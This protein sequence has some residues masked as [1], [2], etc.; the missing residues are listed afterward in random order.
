MM[1]NSRQ[2][3]SLDEGWRFA[4]GH[5]S[6]PDQ[7][8]GFGAEM[9]YAKS[10]E[11]KGATHP[12]FQDAAW[13]QVELPHDWAVE[14]PFDAAAFNSKGFKPVGRK[15]SATSVGWYRRTFD[16]PAADANRRIAVEF[17]GVFRDCTVWFNGHC[18]GRNESGYCSFRC[19]CTDY[20]RFG[21]QNLLVVRVDASFHEGWFYEGAGLYRHV[22]LTTTAPVHVGHWGAFVQAKPGRGRAS[23]RTDVALVNESEQAATVSIRGEVIDAQG[24]AVQTCETSGVVLPPWGQQDVTLKTALQNP[25]LWSLEAPHLYTWRTTVLQDG[26]E[27]DRLDTPFG[28]RSIRFDPDKGFFLNNKPVKIR[29]TCNHQDH[30][31]VGAALPDRLQAFRVERLQEMGCNAIRTSHN[32]PTPELL[33][34]CD[35]L[36]MLIMDEHRMMGS[37]PEILGQLE[38]LVRRDR[39]HPCV[40]LWSILNEEP[41]Q[42]SDTGNRVGASMKRLVHRLDPTRPVTAAAWGGNGFFGAVDVMGVNYIRL[43]D[44]DKLHADHPAMPIVGS[45]EGSVLTTRGIYEK[46]ATK[47]YVTS[48]DFELPGWGKPARE[49][50]PFFEN[51][52]FLAGTFSWT[53]FDY[54]GE[55]YPHDKWPCISSNF[56]TLDTCG[57]P[58]DTFYYFQSWWT[59]KT[60]LHLLP[61]WNWPG[62]EGQEID[63]W[64]YSNCDEV[65]LFLNDQSLGRKAMPRLGHLSWMVPYAPGLLL[66]KGYKRGKRIAEQRVETTGAPTAIQLTPDRAIIA[67]DGRD[68]SVV[69]VGVLDGQGRPVPVASNEVRFTLSGPGKIIGVGNGDP[70]CHEPDKFLAGSDEQPWRRSLF[71]GLAQIIV[72]AGKEPGELKLQA[73]AQ[74]LQE[75]AAIIGLQPSSLSDLALWRYKPSADRLLVPGNPPPSAKS[76]CKG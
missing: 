21:A 71:N 47:G 55:P 2:R 11:A 62:K 51:R 22:W 44:M 52:P 35:R 27:V 60:V 37:T 25:A 49:W 67:A 32:P 58:K 59:S 53:G 54:R 42:G 45:E 74:G 38:R 18:L 63:V 36:G 9:T 64:C 12:T 75:C 10:G 69:T 28:I 61:H 3:L 46:D 66:A 68:V 70:S 13:R 57:F 73:E 72:Q 26:R 14:L 15:C 16:I 65:E 7:D 31:G 48:Y 24:A 39:N 4:L 76:K 41:I 30:A 50:V 5:A 43:G 19:D 33:D 8:F 17:D 29:G 23:I 34:A 1:E 6:D 40:I 20:A 56:G